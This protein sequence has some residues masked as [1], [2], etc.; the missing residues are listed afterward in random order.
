M[1]TVCG[2]NKL[3][4]NST[5]LSFAEEEC[6]KQ[7]PGVNGADAVWYGQEPNS[8][9]DFG[10]DFTQ[11]ARAPINAS[12]QRKKGTITDLDASGGYNSDVTQS[13]LARMMQGFCFA[14]AREQA[15]THPM[16]GTTVA[17]TG[18][19]ATDIKYEAAA[20]LDRFAADDLLFASGFAVPSNNGLKHV[21]DAAAAGVIVWGALADEA[22]AP[23]NARLQKVGKQFAAGD[24]AFNFTGGVATLVATAGSFASM[25][26][27]AGSWIFIGGDAAGTAFA[28]NVGFARVSAVSADGKTLTLD[29][30]TWTPVTEGGG[31]LTLQVFVG[32]VI[33]N[34][35][36]PANIVRRS[37]QLERTL[38]QDAAGTQSEYIIGAV[39]NQFTLNIP[40]ADLLNADLTFVGCD[41]EQRTG[42][43]GVKAGT[44]IAAPG[45]DGFNTASDVYRM[46]MYVVDDADPNPTPLFG[47]VSEG[48]IEI[49]NNVT[50]NKAVGTLG[51]FD[52][53]AGDFEVSGSVTAYFT[54]VAATEAVRNN[55]DVGLYAISAARN[56][57]FLFDIPLIALGGGRIGVEKDKEITVPL[58]TNAAESKFGHT[59]LTEW[60]SYL[61]DVAM[62]QQ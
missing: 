38:G 5:G 43:Q 27:Q 32:T 41:V 11:T 35:P 25:G 16:N 29:Q 26:L 12:R 7:L 54:T 48:K 6:L 17:I 59:L 62:P 57:G 52:T 42:A 55:A 60:F 50:P 22:A 34:E 36:D 45:E 24:V 4:S 33:R 37:Y 15:D 1:P 13:N 28:N 49:N 61:P 47:Y 3:D 58:D 21:S 39:A 23:T 10:G 20:G 31:A 2:T 40:S 56:G 19:D 46:R 14:S 51:A 44:R 30:T 18:V 8:Y 9:S 53:T